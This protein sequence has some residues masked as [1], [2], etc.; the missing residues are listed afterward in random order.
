MPRNQNYR[1]QMYSI[2]LYELQISLSEYP[3]FCV[4]YPVSEIKSCTLVL[5]KCFICLFN[6]LFSC[7]RIVHH[8]LCIFTVYYIF[9]AMLILFLEIF[10]NDKSKSGFLRTVT[11]NRTKSHQKKTSKHKLHQKR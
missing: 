11:L 4:N 7:N 8:W 10:D 5:I 3:L 6:D 1:F 9:G 2:V